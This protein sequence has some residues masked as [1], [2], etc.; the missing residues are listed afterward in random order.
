[1]RYTAEVSSIFFFC[2]NQMSCRLLINREPREDGEMN[3]LT[4]P[5]RNWILSPGCL[6][7]STLPLIRRGSPQYRIDTRELERIYFK[8]ES[9]RRDVTYLKG[10]IASKDLF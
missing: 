7:P 4:L 6:R 5:S 8:P 1:M 3:Q 2:K 10:V 9:D